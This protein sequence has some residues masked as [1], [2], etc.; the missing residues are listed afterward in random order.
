MDWGTLNPLA[1]IEFNVCEWRF[2]QE[3]SGTPPR[4]AEHI[5]RGFHT[6]VHVQDVKSDKWIDGPMR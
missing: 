6:P 2:C 5:P 3:L 4:A 1:K